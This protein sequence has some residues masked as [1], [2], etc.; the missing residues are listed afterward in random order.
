MFIYKII[1]DKDYEPKFD[2]YDVVIAYIVVQCSY[3]QVFK[4]KDR[5]FRISRDRTK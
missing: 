3:A 2:Y 1:T 4:N 5:F